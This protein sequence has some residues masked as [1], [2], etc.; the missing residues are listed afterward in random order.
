MQLGLIAQGVMLYLS[1]FHTKAVW[2][3]F[4]TWIRTIRPNV[5]P[6]EMVVGMSLRNVLIYFLE[7]NKFPPNLQK[8][9]RENTLIP[10]FKG[11]RLTG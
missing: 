10:T 9:I 5:R 8:F 2:G 7:G 11:Y 6:T 1:L 3:C 4:E